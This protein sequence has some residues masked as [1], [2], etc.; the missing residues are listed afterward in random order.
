MVAT[1]CCPLNTD[2]MWQTRRRINCPSPKVGNQIHRL[3]LP[4]P[5]AN[6]G[7]IVGDSSSSPRWFRL[8]TR[9][10]N[11]TQIFDPSGRNRY[12][13]ALTKPYQPE[14]FTTLHAIALPDP[15]DDSASNQ[16]ATCTQDFRPRLGLEHHGI[17]L[18]MQRRFRLYF[19]TRNWSGLI[20]H[21]F[22]G[23]PAQG[24]RF[25]WTSNTFRNTVLTRMLFSFRYRVR[26]LLR[27]Q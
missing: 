11:A 8:L 23:F 17:L 9:S 21:P 14:P 13:F 22:D 19:A 4:V 15:A 2:R 10:P 20:T 7:R 24:I 27:S 25:T 12:P 3:P 1:K 26:I 6:G 5:F 16:P 18:V